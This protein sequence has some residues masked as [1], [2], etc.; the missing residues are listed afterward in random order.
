M[1]IPKGGG[2]LSSEETWQLPAPWNLYNK[3]L[4]MKTTC[5]LL[6]LLGSCSLAQEVL[7]SQLWRLLDDR[8]VL[9]CTEWGCLDL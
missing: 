1:K 6:Q 3:F 5:L 4:T 8:G 2:F 7:E 9:V